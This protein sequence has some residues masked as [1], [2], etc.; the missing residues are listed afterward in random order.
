V[1]VVEVNGRRYAAPLSRSAVFCLDGCDPRYLDDAFERGIVS[2]LAELVEN[3]A[4]TVGRS[5]LPSFTNPNNLSIVT[6]APPSVHGLPGNHYLADDGTEVQLVDPSFL[7][8]PSIHAVLAEAGVP[9][10][11]VTTKDKLRRL[12][13]AGDVPCVSAEKA[14]EQ[15]VDGVARASDLVARPK[16]GIYDWDCSHYALELG[17]ALA[18]RLGTQLLYVS[19]TDFVQ[20]ADPPGGALSDRYLVKLD[21]LVGAYLD[22]GWRLALVADHGMNAKSEVVYLGD[23]LDRAGVDAHVI[24]PITDP[25]VVH[26]AALGSAC[27]VHVAGDDLDPARDLIAEQPGVEEVLGRGE[28]SE[29]LSL[30][31]DR[32]GDLVVLADARTAL[33]RRRSEH[34]LSAL[35]GSLRSHGGRHEQPVPILLSEQPDVAGKEL[36]RAGATNADVHALLLGSA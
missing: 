19:L 31:A 9:V 12:L 17:L 35:Q 23:A 29:Q 13:A 8:C 25:Y 21:E 34:D 30:P 22:A 6:G 7:R 5:Q 16:P 2:R 3:G 24:L 4:Y 11:A 33:G 26:H 1:T 15:A 27:W 36:L 18:E 32:I 10:L 14:D 20:H 28:A